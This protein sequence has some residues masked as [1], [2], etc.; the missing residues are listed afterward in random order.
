MPNGAEVKPLAFEL[1]DKDREILA[2]T[3]EEF[4]FHTWEGLKEI[5]AENNLSILK[6]KPS[7]LRRYLTWASEAKA[8]YGSITNY[9]C[10]ER[11]KWTPLPDSTAKTGPIVP[12]KNPVPF[13]DPDDYKILLND[14]PYGLTPDITHFVVWLKTPIPIDEKTGDLA[15]ESRL[16]I[17]EF[18]QKTFTDRLGR[19]GP[20]EDSVLS[21]KNWAALQSVRGLEHVHVLVRNVPESVIDEWTGE[22]AV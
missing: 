12:F 8:A 19:D 11:L 15:P 5:I 9:V 3:D 13:A 16:L 21:F 1:N 4:H 22:S 6:R 17:S 7:D 18:V 10:Q 14:W 20:A 2:Q